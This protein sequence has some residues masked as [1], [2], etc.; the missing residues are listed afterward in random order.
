[1]RTQYLFILWCAVLLSMPIAIA[2]KNMRFTVLPESEAEE[3][4]KLCSRPGAPKFDGTWKPTAADVRS[5]ETRLSRIS[6]LR[7]VSGARV[8]HPDRYYRQYIGILVKKRKL[9]YINALCESFIHEDSAERFTNMCDGGNCFWGAVYDVS[10]EQF[11]D[12]NMNGS[13]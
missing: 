6:D 13:P 2:Q 3:A 10:T 12:L 8:A 1:M 11:S 9:I 4:T 7:D 5:L